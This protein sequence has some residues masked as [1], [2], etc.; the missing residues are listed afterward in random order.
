MDVSATADSP[1]QAR[2][3]ANELA[4][5]FIWLASGL[6]TPPDSATPVVRLTVIDA[7]QDGTPS[8][9]LPAKLIYI[10]GGLVGFF[11]GLIVAFVLRE[12]CAPH[13]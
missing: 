3:I 12:L 11:A 7:A 9:L 6:E 13:P 5:Q 1:T 8:R 4:N 2:D 10:F